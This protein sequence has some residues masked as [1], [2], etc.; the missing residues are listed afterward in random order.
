MS[1]YERIKTLMVDKRKV[2]ADRIAPH[3]ALEDLGLDSVELS[4]LLF[5]I[6]DDFKLKLGDQIPDVTT[7]ADVVAFVD[8]ALAHRVA[9]PKP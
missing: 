6:E 2:P 5:N 7:V 4:E 1:T 3:I 8:H 9:S